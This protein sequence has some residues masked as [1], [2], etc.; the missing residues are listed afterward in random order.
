MIL[1]LIGAVVLA[2]GSLLKAIAM[3]VLGLLLGLV[4]TDVNSGTARFAF[5]VPELIDGIGVV[6]VAM[7]LFGFAEIIVNLESTEKRIRA[8]YTALDTKV[9]S[10]TAL[11]TYITQQITNWNKSKD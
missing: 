10:L 5:G 11:N 1:G 2:H 8:Q 9:A 6:S 4:G 7:G 3:V